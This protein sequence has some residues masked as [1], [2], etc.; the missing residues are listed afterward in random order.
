MQE[1]WLDQ[2]T[3]HGRIK[4]TQSK[5]PGKQGIVSAENAHQAEADTREVVRPL[6]GAPNHLEIS[7]STGLVSLSLTK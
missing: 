4:F 3:R 6:S 1:Y 7:I 2:P 5:G